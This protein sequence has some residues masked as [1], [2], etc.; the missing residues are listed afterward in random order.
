MDFPAIS[1]HQRVYN[2]SFLTLKTYFGMETSMELPWWRLLLSCPNPH[3]AIGFLQWEAEVGAGDAHL[4][5]WLSSDQIHRSFCLPC[6]HMYMYVH[7]SVYIYIYTSTCISVLISVLMNEYIC[8]YIHIYTYVCVCMCNI[9][10]ICVYMNTA[11]IQIS[12]VIFSGGYPEMF[13][14]GTAAISFTD[15]SR[16]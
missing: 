16:R 4:M 13:S 2:I 1:D 10:I 9:H 6:I 8:I 15:S 5:G 14:P 3:L 11:G 7:I 12:Y